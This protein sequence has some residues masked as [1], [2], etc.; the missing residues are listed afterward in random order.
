MAPTTRICSFALAVAAFGFHPVEARRPER[1]ALGLY[2]QARLGG[3]GDA[4]QTY[5]DALTAAPNETTVALHAYRHAVIRGDYPLAL[6]AAQSLERA[7]L[8]PPDARLLFFI[9]ALRDRDWAAATLRL[10][11]IANGTEFG[12]MVPL[13]ADWL[14]FGRGE[15]VTIPLKKPVAAGG[16]AYSQESRA[17]LML[18]RGDTDGGS[19][20]VK[21]LWPLDSYRSQSLR[22]TAAATLA[23]QKERD[24]A[25]ALLVA[26]DRSTATAR[27]LIAKGR[28]LNF[29]I[30]TPSEGVAF[31]LSRMAG[32]LIVQ[33]SPRA[34]VTLSRLAQFADADN[35]RIALIVAGAFAIGKEKRIALDLSDQLQKDPVYG[36]DASSLR[37]DMLEAVGDVDEAITAARERAASS[38][39]DLARVGEIEVRRGNFVEAATIF[40][41]AIALT[42]GTSP[43]A[44]LLYATGNALDRAGDW[45]AARPYLE[46]ALTMMPG[47]PALLNELGYGLISNGED[48]D[49]AVE[50]LSAAARLK[51]DSAAIMDSVGWA[52]Y[53]LGRNDVAIAQLEQAVSL[54]QAEPEI[55]EHL[56]DAYWRA[57]RRVDARY[58][59]AAARVQANG[60]M[61]ARL[62]GKINRGLP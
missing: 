32:D 31:L 48:M 2:A 25:V 19:I 20:L 47:N 7:K 49:R 55:G 1:S 54:D 29:A 16:N 50:F 8:Y 60:A 33:A 45:K 12:F 58:S 46:R 28:R 38:A 13:L 40:R 5:N 53:R 15:P 24:A 44:A 42:P 11:D 39:N 21:T 35:P 22:L 27:A 43:N 3:M 56:G 36:W 23:A 10:N 57:G 61:A 30:T 9:A 6:R 34:A 41:Q 51:P 4:V 59:W 17:L 37:I 14:S 62:D 52:N 18:A 26:D